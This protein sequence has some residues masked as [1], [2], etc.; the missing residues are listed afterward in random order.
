MNPFIK[1]SKL[2]KLI[3]GYKCQN[4]GYFEVMSRVAKEGFWVLLLNALYLDLGGSYAAVFI[5]WRFIEH[6]LMIYVLFNKYA[7]LQ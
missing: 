6:I 4:A 7:I 3:Y 5:L 1:S 2:S